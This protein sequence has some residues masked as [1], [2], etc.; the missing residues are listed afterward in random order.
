[1][2]EYVLCSSSSEEEAGEVTSKHACQATRIDASYVFTQSF[3]HNSIFVGRNKKVTLRNIPISETKVEYIKNKVKRTPPFSFVI[4]FLAWAEEPLYT[5]TLHSEVS[6]VPARFVP[7]HVSTDAKQIDRVDH[8]KSFR[9]IY[10]EVLTSIAQY[11]SVGDVP[12]V[13]LEGS[14]RI[15]LIQDS[16]L[17]NLSR[18]RARLTVVVSSNVTRILFHTCL[19]ENISMGTAIRHYGESCVG[20]ASL[21]K[22][23][24]V[25]VHNSTTLVVFSTSVFV[26]DNKERRLHKNVDVPKNCD[27]LVEEDGIRIIDGYDENV[28]EEVSVLNGLDLKEGEYV[29]FDRKVYNINGNELYETKGIDYESAFLACS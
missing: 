20:Q 8:C 24:R 1:M 5:H 14:N 11:P 3:Y 26:M 9:D 12:N 18:F 13:H 22:E 10:S 29:L 2:S 6:P 7:V 23:Y 15:I 19:L 4:A 16:V 25:F 28:D 21:S 17:N 27:V